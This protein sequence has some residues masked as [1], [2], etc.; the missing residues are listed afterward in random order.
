MKYY[1]KFKASWNF[2]IVNDVIA[3]EFLTEMKNVVSL[4]HLSCSDYAVERRGLFSDGN[5]EQ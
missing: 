3:S 2:N 1:K 4:I 5:I